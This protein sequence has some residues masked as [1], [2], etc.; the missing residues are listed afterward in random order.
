LIPSDAQ[1][2]GALTE[3]SVLRTRAKVGIDFTLLVIGEHEF[4]IQIR[5]VVA[6]TPVQTD[7]EVLLGGFRTLMGAMLG[8]AIGAGSEDWHV[9]EMG[10][11]AGGQPSDS[12]KSGIPITV[13][14]ARDLEICSRLGRAARQKTVEHR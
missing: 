8:A 7:I 3:V 4:P 9:I 1:L 6:V 2:K 11:V 12:G 5:K 13:V 14:L 10:I